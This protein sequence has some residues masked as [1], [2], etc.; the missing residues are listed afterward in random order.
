MN[1][2]KMVFTLLIVVLGGIQFNGL[3]NLIQP[4]AS[5]PV[6]PDRPNLIRAS[7][8]F[9]GCP[10]SKLHQIQHGIEISSSKTGIGGVLL[11]S[12]LFTESNF[13]LSA[14]SP[15]GYRGIAQT[16][17]ASMIYPE[18]DILHGAM[19]LKDKLRIT[20]NNMFEALSLYK[21]GRNPEARRQAQQVIHIYTNL[22]RR[23]GQENRIG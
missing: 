13:R 11:T 10:G 1:T 18:V 16:P 4:V 7:L 22:M 12:L 20:N 21:G 2:L 9:L 6:E 23:A 14:T 15:K 19:I 3:S 17:T 8:V 5:S